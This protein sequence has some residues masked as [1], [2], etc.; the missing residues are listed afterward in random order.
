MLVKASEQ[1]SANGQLAALL[2][3]L[4]VMLKCAQLPFHGWL[5]QVMEAPTPVSALLHAGIVN[6]GGF[7]LMRFA[8]LLS[9]APL[10]MSLLVV[11]GTLTA[12]IAALVMTTRVSVK[13]MLAW[14]T[15]AQMGFMILQCGLGLWGMALLHL[16]AHSCYKAYAFLDANSMVQLTMMRR[17]R[18]AREASPPVSLIVGAVVA[19]VVT[20][21]AGTLV[22]QRLI[23]HEESA[24]LFVMAVILAMALVP[25]LVAGSGD[26]SHAKGAHGLIIYARAA[27]VSLALAMAYFALH[28]LLHG[29][30]APSSALPEHSLWWFVAAGFI[31]LFA[32]QSHVFS[33]QRTDLSSRLYPW[34]YGGFFLDEK[35]NQLA[36]KIWPLPREGKAVAI[37]ATVTPVTPVEPRT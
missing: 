32:L 14:S 19:A 21:A 24:S 16:V 37:E 30:I 18:S 36:F 27:A 34:F 4:A 2:I 13:V 7:V 17:L 33:G 20:I 31:G 3:V 8:S 5:I 28:A 35:F 25:L 6:L 23:Q 22:T 29:R 15:C 11:A 26:R 1:V 10:A 9:Q 12:V